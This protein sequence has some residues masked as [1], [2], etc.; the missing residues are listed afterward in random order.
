MR[1]ENGDDN[2]AALTVSFEH[3]NQFMKSGATFER[4]QFEL[5]WSR[6][7]NSGHTK[8]VLPMMNRSRVGV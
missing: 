4:T 3:R 1:A 5:V 6:T 8:Q 2:R 7:G